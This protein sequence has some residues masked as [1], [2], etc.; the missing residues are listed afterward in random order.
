[1]TRDL[2]GYGPTPPDPRWPNNARVAVNFVVNYE[3]GAENS[4]L[5]GDERSEAFLSDMVGAA[6]HP[7]TRCTEMEGDRRWGSSGEPSTRS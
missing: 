4:T 6:S 2:T 7:W 1:M 5:N 3:E